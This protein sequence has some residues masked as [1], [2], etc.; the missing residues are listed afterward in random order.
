MLNFTYDVS[1]EYIIPKGTSCNIHIFDMHR[2]PK[3]YPNPLKFDP[4][5]FLAENCAKRH[6]FAYIPFSA[7]PRNCI[8]NIFM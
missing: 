5:R 6:R 3:I 4:D 7:G 8:G 1:D 2:D